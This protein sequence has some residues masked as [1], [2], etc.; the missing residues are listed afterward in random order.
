MNQPKVTV[1]IPV[2]KAEKDIARCCRALF[3]QTLDSIEYIFVND[4]TPDNSVAVIEQVLKEYPQRKL[5]VKIIHQPKNCGVSACRQLGLEHATGGYIIHCDSDDWPELDMY[6]VLYAKAVAEDAEVVCCDYIVEYE[7]Q[8]ELV[9]FPDAHVERPSFNTDPIEG[10]VWNK[11]ISRNLIG[12]CEAEFYPGINLGEDFGFVTPCR[13]MSKKNVVVHKPLYHYNQ[14]NLGSITH[15]YSKERFMQVVD[16]AGRVDANMARLGK[17]DE[18]RLE[19]CN[20]KFLSKM[21]FLVFADVRDVKLWKSLFPECHPFILSYNVPAYLKVSAWLIGNHLGW[22]GEMILSL[23][24][25]VS[26]H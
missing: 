23:K 21:Y 1:I 22:L 12:R 3:G 5:S 4:C 14:L 19:L 17:D 10:A 9:V 15:N 6:E 20:L 25:K 13:I 2:Y 11:L 8:S 16:L 7:G 18:Y 26:G 24:S